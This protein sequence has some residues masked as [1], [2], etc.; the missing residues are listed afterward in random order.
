MHVLVVA[1]EVAI[2]KLICDIL[3]SHQHSAAV[4]NTSEEATFYYKQ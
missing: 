2:S 4:A 3:A 1:H